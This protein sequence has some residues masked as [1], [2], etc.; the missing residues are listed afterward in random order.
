MACVAQTAVHRKNQ[1]P[2]AADQSSWP[3]TSLVVSGNHAYSREQILAVAGLRIGQVVSKQA[4]EAARDRLLETGNFRTVGYNYEPNAQANGY[5][6]KLEVTEEEQLYPIGFD[7]LPA[8]DAELRE[9]LKAKDPLYGDKVPATEPVVKRYLQYLSSYLAGKAYHEKI[10]G[11]L[12]SESSPDLVLLFRPAVR[13]SIAQVRFTGN[14][15]LRE[16]ELQAAIANVAIGTIYVAP[17]FQAFLENSVRPAYEAKGY[18]RVTFPKVSTEK[19][20]DVNGI[21][22][23]V[24]VDEGQV[25]RLTAVKAP[26]TAELIKLAALRTGDVYDGNLVAAARQKIVDTWHRRGY[27][28]ASTVADKQIDD[29]AKTVTVVLHVNSGPQYTF[30]SLTINGLDVVSE[31]VIRKMWGMPAG[32]A[33][34]VDYPERFLKVVRE[35]GILDNLGKTDSE[36]KVDEEAHVV[37]VTLT[38]K[39]APTERAKKRKEGDQD[40]TPSDGNPSPENR[41]FP[42]I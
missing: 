24:A 6:G 9:V 12:A 25:Y 15:A 28:R 31:P 11:A 20:S 22:V 19:A 21:I 5:A 37:D 30:R 42:L 39:G 18:L 1:A 2:A 34:N 41:P 38:F 40:Q 16:T 32:H 23:T 26:E 14:K 17:R 8:T 35:E 33:Y 36:T 4:F 7:S 3:L 13:P 10:V 27:L 29:K